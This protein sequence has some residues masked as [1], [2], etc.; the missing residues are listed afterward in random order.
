MDVEVITLLSVAHCAV[1]RAQAVPTVHARG[2]GR[3][4]ILGA[5]V[6]ATCAVSVGEAPAVGH[7][8]T[9]IVRRSGV[10]VH[11]RRASAVRSRKAEAETDTD[12]GQWDVSRTSS[13]RC[14]YP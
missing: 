12:S 7:V 5:Q 1:R 9:P 2:A 11:V 13:A 4:S 6:S 10:R 14:C 8:M 3:A